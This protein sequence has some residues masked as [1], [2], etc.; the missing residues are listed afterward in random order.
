MIP[1][2]DYKKIMHDTNIKF[3]Y[4]R[5]NI[6]FKEWTIKENN[7]IVAIGSVHIFQKKQG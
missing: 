6:P 2:F 5:L 1:F 7:K 3:S 4:K